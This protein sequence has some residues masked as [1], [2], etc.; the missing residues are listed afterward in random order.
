MFSI[1][2]TR[3]MKHVR[4]TNSEPWLPVLK[5]GQRLKQSQ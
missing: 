4:D 5:L 1:F 2:Y 3:V